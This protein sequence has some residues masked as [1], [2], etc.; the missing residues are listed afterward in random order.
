M[1]LH[2]QIF[3][4]M[5]LGAV[6]GVGLNVWGSEA[7]PAD[8]LGELAGRLGGLFLRLLQLVSVPLIVTSLAAGIMGLSRDAGDTGLRRL[9]L[10]TLAYYIASS[11]LA[12]LVGLTLVNLIRPGLRSELPDLAPTLDTP[13]APVPLP[14]VLLRQLEAL[15][16][17]NLF[18]ALAAPNFLGIIAFTLVFSI[19]A[20]HLGGEPHRRLLQLVED[21]QG[22]MLAVT[23]G[24]IRL[25]PAG[26]LLL[27]LSVT[28]SQGV[29]VFVSLGWYLGTVLLGLLIHAA[30]VLPLLLWFLAGRSALSLARVLSPALLTAFSSASSSGA[31]PLSLTCL[32][33]G[34][35]VSNRTS[36]FVL[37]LGSTINMDGTALYEVVA[38]LF[39]AQLVHGEVTLAQQLVVVL[40]ALLA[41]IGAAGIPHAGLVMMV[42]ILQAVNLPLELQGVVLAVDRVLDMGRTTVNV[43]SDCVGATILDRFEAR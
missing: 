6:V 23:M 5:L 30:V 37:P 35:G 16:P 29:Q 3:I 32:Q 42:I 40:T 7:L 31:L 33:K 27:M 13:L 34:A 38:V 43:W 8:R 2:W 19:F 12:I 26:V 39:I 4:G 11:L 18:A 28:A 15:V 10:R 1:K 41:S 36:S 9:F 17:T 25:A 20:V 14:E 22:V 24:I 21:L